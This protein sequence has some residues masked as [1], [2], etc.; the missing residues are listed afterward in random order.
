MPIIGWLVG[1][2]LQNYIM[3]IDHWIAFIL[4]AAI[5]GKMIYDATQKEEVQKEQNLKFHTLLTLSFATS[6]DALMVGLSFA[7][8]QT[9][10][11]LPVIIIGVITFVLCFLGFHFGC[12]LEKIVGNKIKIVG[13]NFNREWIEICSSTSVDRGIHLW[14]R[15]FLVGKLSLC[16][17]YCGSTRCFCAE[18][19]HLCG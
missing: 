5:G 1:V 6:L 4:L 12:T 11:W 19:F 13:D 3:S 10:I 17:S 8:L 9:A 7:F 2:T 14:I 18:F 15:N 16:V